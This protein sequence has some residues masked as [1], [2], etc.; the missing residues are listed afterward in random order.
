MA[1]DFRFENHLKGGY[2]YEQTISLLESYRSNHYL[3]SVNRA[4][5]TK[6]MLQEY[7]FDTASAGNTIV[8]L[9]EYINASDE[10]KRLFKMQDA[11]SIIKSALSVNMV[12]NALDILK[13]LPK[14]GTRYCR[15]LYKSYIDPT[16][17]GL[18][19]SGLVD[20]FMADFN[21][22]SKSTYYRDRDAA[23]T[24]LSIAMWGT[25]GQF[26]PESILSEMTPEVKFVGEE[27]RKEMRTL[28]SDLDS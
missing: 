16:T 14:Y 15:I 10:L 27:L 13:N 17:D 28:L 9:M 5:A 26:H 22:C 20:L 18:P 8:D 12:N 11:M 1:I 6:D 25:M 2:L 4:R 21:G 19:I 7:G 23:I 24:Q 3:N